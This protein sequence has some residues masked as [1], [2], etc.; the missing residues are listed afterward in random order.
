MTVRRNFLAVLVM[1]LA[2]SL[3]CGGG[4]GPAGV[5]PPATP[6]PPGQ[7]ASLRQ[8]IVDY[9]YLACA[10]SDV[11]ALAR[12]DLVVLD[13]T[14]IWSI[15]PNADLCAR[16]RAANPSIKILAYLPAKNTRV[17]WAAVDPVQEPF[18]H[19]WHEALA[20]YRCW[21][22][23]GDTLLDWPNSWVV[24]IL[25]PECRRRLVDVVASFQ[26]SRANKVD[27]VFWDYFGPTLWISPMVAPTME[28]DPD[29]DG[30]GIGHFDDPAEMAGF[31][32]ASTA[33]LEQ[34]QQ[35]L[36]AGFIQIVN[37][38][39]AATDS[40]FAA[41][42]DGMFYEL[43]PTQNF[44]PGPDMRLALEPTRYNNLFAARHWPRTRNGGPWLIL[45]NPTPCYYFDDQYQRT[46]LDLDDIN[47]VVA[48]LT[49]ATVS[50][51]SNGQ[52][53]YGWPAVDLALGEPLGGVTWDGE[54]ISRRFA[55]GSV[56]AT[57]TSGSFP[58]PFDF[59]I[60]QDGVVVQALD[61]PRHIP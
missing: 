55:R 33:L 13:A 57:F 7:N 20:P 9:R 14:T 41:L 48:L 39:R 47:R 45:S 1:A 51:S 19:A 27:G 31:R 28:G 8:A 4:S 18:G 17:P 10:D 15:V 11:V 3:G 40:A 53:R 60:V 30:N 54:T 50:Y 26:E 12:A 52:M 61:Y 43:F 37:G 16:L 2:A 59:E 6:P 25:E 29:M 21:T 23:A 38:T 44:H 46:L 34:M 5:D 56:T 22:T 58:L 36:G 35:E 42:T 49:G 32:A 24:N